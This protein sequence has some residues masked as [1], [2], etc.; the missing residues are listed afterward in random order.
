MCKLRHYYVILTNNVALL[1][2]DVINKQSNQELEDL[3]DFGA[4]EPVVV[5]EHN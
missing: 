3:R 5:E 4:H 1:N 2:V